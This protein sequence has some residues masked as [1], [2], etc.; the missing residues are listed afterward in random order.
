M[1]RFRFLSA[2]LALQG[3]LFLSSCESV[4]SPEPGVSVASPTDG[5]VAVSLNLGPVGVLARSQQMKPTRLILRFTSSQSAPVA[6]T[7]QVSGSGTVAKTYSLPSQQNWS[8]QATGLDQ[9]DS[10]LYAGGTSFSVAAKKT[11]AVSLSLSAKYSSLRVRFPIIDSLTRFVLSV[12]GTTWGDSTV[13][14]QT[15]V[16]DTVKMDHDYLTASPSGVMHEFGLRIYGQPWGVDTLCYALDTS[17]S[18]VSG[19]SLGHVF[20]VHWVGAKTPPPGFAELTVFLGAVGQV[21]VQVVY[22]DT[23]FSS[24]DYG[25]PWNPSIAYGKLIDS[26]DGKVYRTVQIGGQTWMAENLN[27]AGAGVCYGNIADNCSKFGRL[28]TWSQAVAGMAGQTIVQGVC[29]TGWHVPSDA[30]W[31]ELERTIGLAPDQVEAME[32]RNSA[33]VGN[34]LKAT[35]GWDVNVGTDLYGFRAIPGGYYMFGTEFRYLGIYGD[36]WSSTQN[37]NGQAYV[38][39]FSGPSGGN[40]RGLH[41]QTHGQSIRCLRN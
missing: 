36:F 27:W 5:Q 16:G 19:N 34:G 38:R 12:D 35:T 4:R 26:R 17:V 18:V 30:D 6:D 10:V 21:D 33:D 41:T 13:P 31:K 9:R 11:T 1:K 29:P 37:S 23:S 2:I 28:Y 39:D 7:I 24:N 40:Y 32:W 22:E 8:L 25:I 14:K 15:R 20:K 3:S